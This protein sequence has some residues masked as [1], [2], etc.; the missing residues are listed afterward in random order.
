M[1]KKKTII[2]SFVLIIGIAF[3]LF[4][5]NTV[6][7]KSIFSEYLEER[8]GEPFTIVKAFKEYHSNRGICYRVTAKSNRF[9]EPFVMYA[10][11]YPNENSRNILEVKGKKYE[12]EDYYPEVIF[13]NQYLDELRPL[14]GELP[15]MKCR[16]EFEGSCITLDE[17][18][19]GMEACL[20]KPHLSWV[21][22][23]LLTDEKESITPEYIQA[24]ERQ[25]QAYNSYS[26]ELY[27]GI[28]RDGEM[29]S[30][31]EYYKNYDTSHAVFYD[32]M[33]KSTAI[34]KI[35]HLYGG[36]GDSAPVN[37]DENDIS[38]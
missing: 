4:H 10:Y 14:I 3:A 8:Y 29:V 37:T 25:M 38:F 20:Q 26:Y 12:M 5:F 32:F 6:Y 33:E 11:P 23:Y 28:L 31:E 35:I 19:A 21:T 30:E 9:D 24:I 7:V 15:L 18:Q 17:M 22:V 34:K 13:Q 1:K 2:I 36:R 16:I 27:I